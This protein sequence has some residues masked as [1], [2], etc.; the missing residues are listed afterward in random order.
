[1][2]P[3]LTR[4]LFLATGDLDAAQGAVRD[5][6]AAV[7]AK[8]VPPGGEADVLVAVRRAAWRRALAPGR[9]PFR[10]RT[11]HGL[12]V[13][14]AAV[15][16]WALLAPL[17]G[18]ARAALVLTAFAGLPVEE[19]AEA[20][21][22]APA[23]VERDLE[24]A[25]A[26]VE[27]Q[28]LAE[29]V[30]PVESAD[31]SALAPGLEDL[32]A[33][34]A[35]RRRRTAAVV[36]VGT[37][38]SV[39]AVTAVVVGQGGGDGTPAAG[40]D[41][42]ARAACAAAT[43]APDEDYD[44]DYGSSTEPYTGEP[45]PSAPAVA[46]PPADVLVTADDLGTGWRQQEDENSSLLALM[47]LDGSAAMSDAADESVVGRTLTRAE[48]APHWSVIAE[49]MRAEAADAAVEL[50]DEAAVQLLCE[51]G[52]A[53]EGD[54]EAEI[55]LSRADDDGEALVLRWRVTEEADVPAGQ[56]VG[57]L[58]QVARVGDVVS[59]TILSAQA[60]HGSAA[61][62]AIALDDA[63]LERLAEATLDRLAGRAPDEPV[64]L[65]VGE[66]S[67][68]PD[69]ALL[70]QQA[71]FGPGWDA[72]TSGLLSAA[73]T[74]GA[75]ECAPAGPSGETA[76]LSA[77]F[78]RSDADESPVDDFRVAYEKVARFGDAAAAQSHVDAEARR[79]TGCGMA[80]LEPGVDGAVV[81][82]DS[83]LNDYEEATLPSDAGTRNYKVLVV[84][85]DLV[86][87][88]TMPY[89]A[90]SKEERVR[91]LA[92]KAAERLRAG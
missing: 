13:P 35:G 16:A 85:G 6:F 36:A 48:G 92:A 51:G 87:E 56:Q 30:P 1:M 29:L 28:R 7:A 8:D 74:L 3:R 49:A 34:A 32:E 79:L 21:D 10:S 77:T 63:A 20:L 17:P 24:Q 33:R 73:G 23:T 67:S 86:A 31:W 27:G 82:S 90:E 68:L 52:E 78:M 38:A 54:G 14:G 70:L 11:A 66:R 40:P 69:E 88:V 44:E 41:E 72:T 76:S 58:A 22:R 57:A 75:E 5:A 43:V 26:A 50:F 84:E 47:T 15:D 89:L 80:P 83:V 2:A 71:D 60:G 39:L 12:D 19:A 25:R 9:R 4:H 91:D 64:E 46:P 18:S 59:L 42:R 81:L 37:A 61:A 45:T 62:A 55:A 53:D 65:P